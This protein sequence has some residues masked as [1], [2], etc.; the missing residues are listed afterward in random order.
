MTPW[1]FNNG[2]TLRIV[3]ELLLSRIEQMTVRE[4]AEMLSVC[5]IVLTQYVD[6]FYQFESDLLQFIT[7]LQDPL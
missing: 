4:L 6:Q 7:V 3:L 1:S 5:V 2:S